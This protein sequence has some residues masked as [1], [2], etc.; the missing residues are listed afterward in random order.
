MANKTIAEM[1]QDNL[2]LNPGLGNPKGQKERLDKL[3]RAK[4][5]KAVGGGSGPASSN[6]QEQ[7]AQQQVT[8][9][10]T[11]VQTQ[12]LMAQQ[13]VQQQEQQ[14]EEQARQQAQ[15]SAEESKTA[16]AE[17][18]RITTNIAQSLKRDFQK[19][20]MRERE[21]LMNMATTLARLNTKKYI[22]DLNMNARRER[23][24]S[25]AA[26]K[27]KFAETQ[28][29]DSMNFFRNN[30]MHAEVLFKEKFEFREMMD[31]MSIEQ[32]MEL[33]EMQIQ[34]Q[35]AQMIASGLGQVASAGASAYAAY[36][37]NQPGPPT[38]TERG[39][40]GYSGPD[41]SYNP[42]YSQGATNQWHTDFE[43]DAGPTKYR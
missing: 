7:V 42:D 43:T 38:P 8:A 11:D 22:H 12:A 32:A 14:L 17:L 40:G 16:K 19:L 33:G 39:G 1:M 36:S 5:G 18:D 24:D 2:E 41:A 26:W 15:L 3:L 34:Q 29:A 31:E 23:I 6:I 35:Q 27:R 28:A 10:Q 9:A 30:M 4:S 20:D 13:G 21:D 25:E 37:K